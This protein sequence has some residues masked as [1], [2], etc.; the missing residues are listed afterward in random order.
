[1]TLP[2]EVAAQVRQ[3]YHGINLQNINRADGDV[4]VVLRYNEAD[5]N[6]L[7]SLENMNL[8]LPTGKTV[9]LSSVADINYGEGASEIKHHQR[10]R[11]VRVSAKVDDA[12][13]SPA[14]VMAA[15]KAD[16][17]DNLDREFPD[18]RWAVAG[19]Q[20]EREEFLD[21]LSKAYLMALLGMYTLMA[22]Q[23]RSYGQPLMV[24]IA[25]PFGLI[26]ALAGH[27]IVGIDVTIWSLIG[28][29]AVS[30]VV[31][32]DNLVLID[33]INDS[34][35]NGMPL[36]QAIRSAGIQRARA[37]ILISLTTLV[38]VLPMIMEK[39][40]QAQF[41]IPMAVS[42]GFGTLFSSTISLILV[43][44][45]YRISAD[46]GDFIERLFSKAPAPQV[47]LAA[48]SDGSAQ[49]EWHVGLDEAY[50]L[51][52]T[53]GRQGKPRQSNFELE[54]LAAS[55]EAGWDDGTE[56]MRRA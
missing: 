7:W 2:I 10:H 30:G 27:L 44:S 53:A 48:G 40:L 45:M 17:L 32:N 34:R 47:A 4:A 12:A 15:L 20:K 19:A 18:M 23:F 25:I 56:E 39:S 11:V 36:M 26:G 52:F 6:S 31:V 46:I 13:T 49:S 55:W 3:A 21:F 29:V 37:V 41:M 38:G 28:M 24:M 16:F 5:R 8:V 1:M 43:P 54:V 51:G 35:R 9:P 42:L 50:E 14:K 22:F 33:Y